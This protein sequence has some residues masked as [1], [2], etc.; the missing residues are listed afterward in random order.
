MLNCTFSLMANPEPEQ[1][2][3]SYWPARGGIFKHFRS[4]GI[5]SKESILLAYVSW[6]AS[7]TTLFL[8]GS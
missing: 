8:L 3:L 6:R 4:T 5:D 2:Y 7:T 1:P